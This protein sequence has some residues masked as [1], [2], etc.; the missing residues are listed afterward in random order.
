M[1]N[2]HKITIND[3]TY[4]IDDLE[5]LIK[6]A[7][8]GTAGQVL[9]KDADGNNVWATLDLGDTYTAGY[10]I[11]IVDN[12]ISVDTSKIA[13]KEEI[14]NIQQALVLLQETLRRLVGDNTEE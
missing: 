11:N 8:E 1:N 3:V 6:P 9:A 12:V 10:G 7:K 4:D 5:K 2:V 13:T 14:G